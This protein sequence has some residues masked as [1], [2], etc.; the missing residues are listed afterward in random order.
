MLGR[1]MS[2]WIFY[3][4]SNIPKV[5][6]AV[7]Q[8]LYIV[9]S[10]LYCILIHCLIFVFSTLYYICGNHYNIMLQQSFSFHVKKKRLMTIYEKCSS[11]L[12]RLIN[13]FL[14]Y[15]NRLAS[16]CDNVVDTR[17]KQR[18]RSHRHVNDKHSC[19]TD[20]HVPGTLVEQIHLQRVR[21]LK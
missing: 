3:V 4:R 11:C 15:R 17:S 8:V 12:A 20:T 6:G 21:L 14:L 18:M 5:F 9:F 19:P 7:L 1:K 13:M 16:G 2:Y 10:K